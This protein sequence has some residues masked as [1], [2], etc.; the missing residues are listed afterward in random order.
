M[1][2]FGK[3]A[4]ALLLA[5]M[6]CLSLFPSALAED[7]GSIAAEDAPEQEVTIA[8]AEEG[9]IAPAEEG[10]IAPADE[11]TI[12][13]AE[14]GDALP[15]TDET[16][17][18]ETS[19]Q[20][21]DDLSW[22]FDESSG[23]L[24]ITGSGDMWDWSYNSSAPWYS[25]RASIKRVEFPRGLTG[26]G[27]YAFYYCSKLASVDIPAGV[28]GIGDHA[29]YYC[30]GLT[31][32]TIPEGVTSIGNY[33]FYSCYGLTGVTIPSTVTGIDDYAFCSCYGLTNVTI[34][35]SVTSIGSYA[36]YSC[37]GLTG[38]TIPAS[39]TSIG[40]YAFYSC[41]GLTSVVIREGVES[42]MDSAF[43]SCSK[44]SSVTLP[45][46]LTFFGRDVF[47]SCSELQE[48]YFGGTVEAWN[49]LQVS[50]NRTKVTVHC[51]DG[52]LSPTDPAYCGDDLTWSFD[53]TTGTLSITGSG[54]MW[55]WSYPAY[56]PWYS[57]R[58]SII[59]VE[60]PRGLT[61]IGNFAFNDCSKL[62]SV[63]IPAGVTRIGSNAFSYCRGLTSIE[64]PNS[65]RIIYGFAFFDCGLTSLLIPGSVQAIGQMAFRGCRSLTSVVIQ[66]GCEAIDD[67][68]FDSCNSL[69]SLTLPGSLTL[70]DCGFMSRSE[71]RDVYYGGTVDAWK[72]L[73]VSYDRNTVTVH[74]TDAEL[75]PATAEQCGDDLTWSFDESSGTLTITGSGD[76]WDMQPLAWETAN[77][78]PWRSLSGSIK[79][80][81]LPSG[82]T[83]IGDY[84]FSGCSGLTG[85][86]IPSS[87]TSIGNS[88]FYNCSGLT[89]VTIPEGVTSI[90][91][92]AFGSC[93]GLTSVS[94]PA[95]ISEGGLSPFEDSTNLKDIYY[96]GTCSA[97][98][99]LNLVYDHTSVTVHCAD[100]TIEPN[101]DANRCGEDL[102]WSLE[103]GILTITGIGDMWNFKTYTAS[104][105]SS[106]QLLSTAPW[107][108]QRDTITQV[109]LSEGVTGIGNYAFGTH[110]TY[111]GGQTRCENLVSIELPESLE[112][113]G[114]CG[115]AGSRALKKVEL[116]D[117][118]REIGDYAFEFCGLTELSLPRSLEKIGYQ[119]FCGVHLQ[120]LTIPA[121]V[122]EIGANAFKYSSLNEICFLG[123]APA[124]GGA[125][126]F[127][128]IA[129]AYYPQ[130]DPTWTQD[131][132]KDYG[133]DI[134][135]VGALPTGGTLRLDSATVCAGRSFT[136]DL[137]LDE[138]PGMTVLSLGLDYDDAVLEFVGAQEGVLTG[139]T[140]NVK[141]STLFWDSDRNRTDTGILLRLKFR[142]KEDAV[143]GIVSI[144]IKK[145]EA[146]NYDEESLLFQT[147]SGA[148]TVLL[149]T[150]GDAN[151][152]GKVNV[153]DLTRLRKYLVGTETEIVEGNA[154]VNADDVVDILDLIR[155]RKYFV[156]EEGVILE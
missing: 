60:L 86:T 136:V 146:G 140:V 135:W 138:N 148:V 117:S 76:M 139:W 50:Y 156:E 128:L 104:S 124:I 77:A 116:P 58:A 155:M 66:E 95:S 5:L 127:G 149:H 101:A 27:D 23:T 97:W 119:A 88:A 45:G 147:H 121:N 74:C 65:V 100:G 106:Y 145:L 143:P 28:I 44:L 30:S 54:D 126:F 130:N 151:G 152:D 115:L 78:I 103:N 94:L 19:G 13:P 75:L 132:R 70:L 111:G 9:T 102:F 31:G 72:A 85:V 107:Y 51:A 42:I 131:V 48:V 68:V 90:G 123:N 26:I 84:A 11:G 141:K 16:Q 56:A 83:S 43:A 14:E 41:S 120:R 39:V 99:R 3:R 129:T 71:L 150:P 12:A 79:S 33:A 6:L 1:R 36:F 40:S 62:T 10:S 134:T 64:I 21:G 113:I 98:S 46:S 91:Y 96:A 63:D 25:L 15:R 2:H 142:V 108:P 137:T 49:A 24:T 133:G 29:F 118:L 52:D 110:V 4:F 17:D 18:G 81:E 87:V 153:H 109:R 37:S 32:V 7:A 57:L 47:Y 53:E 22:S 69:S 55:D 105:E 89:S 59:S 73:Q 82:L 80:V 144:G 8:P 34:P 93:S 114:I 112:R 20:C 125:A 92:S 38:V 122:T 67:G 61:N 154:D 35:S